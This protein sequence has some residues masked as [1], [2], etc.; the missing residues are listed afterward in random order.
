MRPQPRS[1]MPSRTAAVHSNAPNRLSWTHGS[2]S[3]AS[4][5]GT[6]PADRPVGSPR[7]GRGRRPVRGSRPRG[8][9]R[10]GS[11]RRRWR[12]RRRLGPQAGVAQRARRGLGARLDDVV[13][14]AT[15]P[16]RGQRAAG[17][18]EA[19]GP[20]AAGDQGHPPGQVAPIPLVPH[21]V[22]LAPP[23]LAAATDGRPRLV[24][25]EAGGGTGDGGGAWRDLNRAWWDEATPLHAA[26]ALYDL[27]GFRAGANHIRP[28]ELVELDRSTGSTSCTCSATSAPTRCRGPAWPAPG[29][30]GNTSPAPAMAVAGPGPGLRARRRVRVRRR[31]RQRSRAGRAQVRR[32]VHGHGAVGWLPDLDRW[33]AVVASLL[34]PGRGHRFCVCASV[35]RLRP[36]R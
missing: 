21:R 23:P 33:A 11:P 14:P 4:S 9:P 26:S 20:T 5:P 32:R 34:R 22:L 27:D 35:L 17:D 29:W 36:D 28:F 31:L 6:A 24:A 7:C 18:A 8:R 10:R 15:A 12:R 1:H 3:A 16:R 13:R 2:Q 25:A 19:H 30:W